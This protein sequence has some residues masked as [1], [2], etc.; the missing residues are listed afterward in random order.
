MHFQW[1]FP[2]VR[3]WK[4][5]LRSLASPAPGRHAVDSPPMTPLRT[6]SPFWEGH[7]SAWQG[8]TWHT[9]YTHTMYHIN[10]N[11]L[12]YK[13]FIIY[14]FMINLYIRIDMHIH[15]LHITAYVL[16]I[17]VTYIYIYKGCICRRC[18]MHVRLWATMKEFQDFCYYVII[19]F[20]I[21]RKFGG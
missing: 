5:P 3:W 7:K 8:Y 15:I 18:T 6:E 1:F 12:S 16:N 2:P 20:I 19:I 14:F 4:D 11:V 17:H 9:S 10:V 21:R 13:C